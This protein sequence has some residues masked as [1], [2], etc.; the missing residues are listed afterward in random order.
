MRDGKQDVEVPLR[1]KEEWEEIGCLMGK[2]DLC[3]DLK[4]NSDTGCADEIDRHVRTP[5]NFWA[6]F[7]FV[8]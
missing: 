8:V 5:Q 7:G 4:N 3:A 1:F 2:L 6:M